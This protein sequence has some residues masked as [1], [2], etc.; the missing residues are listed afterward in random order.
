[1]GLFLQAMIMPDCKEAEARA[2]VE[3]V[4]QKHHQDHDP[5]SYF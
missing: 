3:A 4:A 1:M 2:A 5:D